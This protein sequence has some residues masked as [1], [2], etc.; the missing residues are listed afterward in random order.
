MMTIK[1]LMDS[2][3]TETNPIEDHPGQQDGPGKANKLTNDTTNHGATRGLDP[4]QWL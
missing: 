4:N 1:T 3:R 2:D